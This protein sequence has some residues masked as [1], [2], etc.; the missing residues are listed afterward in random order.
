MKLSYI[1]CLQISFACNTK[2]T[3][4][5]DGKELTNIIM[6]NQ[7]IASFATLLE[8]KAK[9]TSYTL[10]SG[11]KGFATIQS[12]KGGY[13]I[14]DVWHSKKCSLIETS[15]ICTQCKLLHGQLSRLSNVGGTSKKKA[16]RIV[17]KRLSYYKSTSSR[18]RISEINLRNE[19]VRV[20]SFVKTMELEGIDE[21]LHK[22]NLSPQIRETIITSVRSAKVKSLKGMR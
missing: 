4:F 13:K 11:V 19:L 21:K 15:T 2:I 20:R 16:A 3:L 9:M 22:L 5:I 14:H 6:E 10:C 18:L 1:Y 17:Q 12:C 7:S 8:L